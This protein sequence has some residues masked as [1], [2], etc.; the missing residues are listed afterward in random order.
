MTATS[1]D[2]RP[3][4]TGTP[5]LDPSAL[6]RRSVLLDRASRSIDIVDQIDG[7]SHDIRLAFH[8]GPDVRA[9]LEES[10]AVLGWPTASAPGTAR[11]ELPPGLRWSLHR[12]ETDPILGWYSHGLGRRVPAVT[13]LGCGRCVPGM[14]L[15]TRLEF[16]EDGKSG[17]SAVSRQ[18]I[19]WTTSAAL[20]DARR[21]RSKRRPDEPAGTGPAEVH[22]D[23]AAAQGF[24]CRRGRPGH[25]R[26]RCL[27]RAQA[28]DA[29]EYRADRAP[30][31][32]E[33]AASRTTTGGTDPFTATQ[34]V[35]AGSY[36]V[37]SDALPDVR[38]AM[39]L[40]ELRRNVQ[41]G[42][43]S[44]DIISVTAQGKNAA[45][46]E[47]TAN[48]V[49]NSYVSYVSSSHSAVGHIRAQLLESANSAS[50]PSPAGRTVIYALVGGLA[51]RG[52]R[53]PCGLGHRPQGPATRAA[54]RY[55]EFDRDSRPGVGPGC[56]SFRRRGLDEAL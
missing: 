31:S 19:S 23:R 54:R 25:P 2:G 15:I 16:L 17:K 18:A 38:P 11:L 14:P 56:S 42:S 53:S 26:R 3:S 6:H 21:R 35:V 27:R 40:T 10:C 47:A 20:S 29:H 52:D 32:G 51:R 5:R 7:G 37:L 24:C 43:P 46:A 1:P 44:P 28:A 9:E 49:A 36:Q 13:L 12:G 39:S 45:D 33:L 50:G 55:S 41:V 48:A 22:A 8:L 34:E 4:T 30:G